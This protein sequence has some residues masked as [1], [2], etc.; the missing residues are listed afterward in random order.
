M[1]YLIFYLIIIKL[2]INIKINCW[3]IL[4]NHQL[5]NILW[6]NLIKNIKIIKIY[7]WNKK[8]IIKYI[9]KSEINYKILKN[10]N[11]FIKIL[12]FIIKLNIFMNLY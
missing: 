8:I 1:N 12:K 2:F 9:K 6:N 3:I 4:I 11:K 7:Y 10:S 5:F